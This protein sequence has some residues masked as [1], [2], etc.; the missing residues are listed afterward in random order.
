MCCVPNPDVFGSP[1]SP[2]GR[3]REARLE[4]E[5]LYDGTDFS[6][7]LTRARFE[8]P[9]RLPSHTRNEDQAACSDSDLET[10]VEMLKDLPYSGRLG[11]VYV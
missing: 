4:I 8:E 10:T 7:T 2:L 9:P 5:A 6:E 1:S 3:I 11:W